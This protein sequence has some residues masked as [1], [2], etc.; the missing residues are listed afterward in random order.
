[1]KKIL[2]FMIFTVAF[3]AYA[4]A[5]FY[6][7]GKVAY[8]HLDTE[9][10]GGIVDFSL[11]GSDGI[12]GYFAGGYALN[13]NEKVTGRAEFEY[14]VTG[15]INSHELY[16]DAIRHN[17]MFNFYGDVTTGTIFTP[18]L[19]AGL[20]G[21]LIE[22]NIISTSGFILGA[23]IGVGIKVIENLSI[24]VGYKLSGF[25]NK[26][27]YIEYNDIVHDLYLTPTYKS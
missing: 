13:F 23:T 24:D 8:T 3:T 4:N 27:Y 9:I 18:F 1:M 22:N 26:D 16:K 14:G 6:V 25:I 11:G 10:D 15:L 17:F 2:F 5:E 21:S 12:S 19:G 7:S 20:G